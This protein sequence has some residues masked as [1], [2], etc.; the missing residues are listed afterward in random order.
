M[1]T[2]LAKRP[3]FGHNVRK[4]PVNGVQLTLCHVSNDVPGHN[5]RRRAQ[6]CILSTSISRTAELCLDRRGG[7]T[8]ASLERSDALWVYA[9][10]VLNQ[11]NLGPT[12]TTNAESTPT[13]NQKGTNQ[14]RKQKP[15][16]PP[17]RR[18]TT[19]TT[20]TI[21]SPFGEALTRHSPT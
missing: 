6:R 7:S 12:N 17:S 14:R 1:G 18:V 13:P 2:T 8:E 3:V 11:P 10:R 9:H 4:S 19:L 15:P 21:H 5:V 20:S 16:R